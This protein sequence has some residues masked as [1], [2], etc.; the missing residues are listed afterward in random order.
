VAGAFSL[1]RLGDRLVSGR[2]VLL[3]DDVLTTGATVDECARVL[4]MAGAEK[5]LVLTVSRAAD[6]NPLATATPGDYDQA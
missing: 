2:T 6:S 3:V 4:K 5:I 1:G